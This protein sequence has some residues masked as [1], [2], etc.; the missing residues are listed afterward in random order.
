MFTRNNNQEFKNLDLNQDYK[1]QKNFEKYAK[2][3]AEKTIIDANLE[4]GINQEQQELYDNY[5][6]DQVSSC[7]ETFPSLELISEEKPVLKN[8]EVIFSDEII[9]ANLDLINNVKIYVEVSKSNYVSIK[10]NTKEH[11][12]LSAD[13]QA[14]I[15]IPEDTVATDDSGQKVNQISLKTIE[16]NFDGLPNS[17]VIG[18]VVYQATPTP[19]SFSK[20]FEL[21][22][23]VRDK[24]IPKNIPKNM[25]S[26][27][28]WHKD[29]QIWVALPT[30]VEGNV[31]SAEADH[32]TNFVII[33]GCN[34][35][36][37][38]I[39]ETPYLFKQKYS[40]KIPERITDEEDI[41]S[42][43]SDFCSNEGDK[44]WIENDDGTIIP[45][46][47]EY[48]KIYDNDNP[49][50]GII[51]TVQEL[52]EEEFIF[53]GERN[54]E[55]CD[56]PVEVDY[57][58]C[59][60]NDGNKV[61]TSPQKC[62]E[63]SIDENKEYEMFS[64]REGRTKCDGELPTREEELFGYNKKECIGGE[65]LDTSEDGIY[66]VRFKQSEACILDED[67]KELEIV[68]FYRNMNKDSVQICNGESYDGLN[69]NILS[70]KTTAGNCEMYLTL[71]AD[72]SEKDVEEFI[73]GT[74]FQIS[75][76]STS[77]KRNYFCSSYKVVIQ[78]SALGI[79]NKEVYTKCESGQEFGWDI[80]DGEPIC[81][82]CQEISKVYGSDLVPSIYE[83]DDGTEVEIIY[84]VLGE[85]VS[86]SNCGG[87][88]EE[89]SEESEY[90]Q[91]DTKGEY[92][93]DPIDG[94]CKQCKR[95]QVSG[96]VL[97]IL[98]GEPSDSE[99]E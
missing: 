61:I 66:S 47:D 97:L 95:M 48:R 94:L 39:I 33:L 58:C 80:K 64:G 90:T 87:E 70:G 83:K 18:N 35:G 13:Q 9:E 40:Y 85:T 91:C 62:M 52:P 99:C 84:Y 59:Y 27:A 71:F 46:L 41:Q 49:D 72:L 2:N 1:L 67:S 15:K 56:G 82:K 10:D 36:S 77:D 54:Q 43:E 25:L 68:D 42:F 3:C 74:K 88:D 55:E 19:I 44:Y 5:V 32:F 89:E 22:I 6:F 98:Y 29:Y 20:P 8:I 31:L 75:K 26:V 14:V 16:K 17:I 73:T 86:D 34:E 21:S 60:E 7:I 50:E 53:G 12:L 30:T 28:Y 92:E 24:D 76:A 37:N 57:I 79:E 51:E 78:L 45:T 65:T 11:L 81:K 23:R 4:Y 93:I 96:E 38:L 69:P 63:K